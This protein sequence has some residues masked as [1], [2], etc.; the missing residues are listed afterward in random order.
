MAKMNRRKFLKVLGQGTAAV[1][2][3]LG[4]P[5]SAWFRPGVA[6]AQVVGDPKHPDWNDWDFYYP[7]KYDAQDTEV[8]KEFQAQ[9]ALMI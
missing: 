4:L 1:S 3:G 6:Q 2:M 5:G 7:G 8:L 9:L